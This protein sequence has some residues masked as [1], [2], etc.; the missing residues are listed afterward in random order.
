MN[1]SPKRKTAILLTTA[2]LGA[3]YAGSAIAQADTSNTEPEKIIEEVLVTGTLIRGLDAPTG[4]NLVTID[5]GQIR[6]SGAPSATELVSEKVTQLPTFNTVPVGAAG[7]ANTVPRLG[8]RGFGN[9]AGNASGGTATLVMFNG[10]RVVFTGYGSSDVDPSSIP[11]DILQTVQ[12]MPDG[13]SAAYGSDAVGGVIN[14]VTLKK[15]DGVQLH[16]QHGTVDDYNENTTSLTAGTSWD[17]GNVLFNTSF[18]NNSALLK[19]DRSYTSADFRSFGGGDY[20]LTTCPDG[21]FVVD[22]TAYAAPDFTPL[23]E[24][25]KCEPKAY[26]SMVPEQDRVSAFTYFEQ[27]I[28]DDLTF[29]VDAFYSKRR[30]RHYKD[31]NA[32]GSSVTIDSSNPYFTPVAGETEQRVNFSYANGIGVNR[33]SPQELTSWQISPSL[34]WRVGDNWVIDSDFIVGESEAEIHDRTGLNTNFVDSTN[35]N[36]YDTSQMP[37][38]LLGTVTNFEQ[39]FIGVN[40]LESARITADGSIFSIEGGDV[41]LAIGAEST[42]QTLEAR[43]RFGAIGL[44][45]FRS[46]DNDR[47]VNAVYGELYVPLV[48]AANGRPG[49]RELNFALAVRYDDYSDFGSTTNPR[50]G[51]NYRPFEDLGI[52]ANYQ[53]TFTAASLADSG[54]NDNQLQVIAN[55]QPDSYRIY[56]AGT[57]ANIDPTEGE[58]Y[59]IG[60]DWTPSFAPGLNV[61]AT[62]WNTKLEN[63]ISQALAAFGGSVPTS[64]TSYALCGDGD[65][66]YS[67]SVNGSCTEAQINDILN[68]LAA[69]VLNP[70]GAPGISTISDLFQPGITVATLIDARRGNFGLENISG[71][72]FSAG[73]DFDTP[74]GN[75]F[76]GVNG[77]VML[78]KEIAANATAPFVN[79]LDGGEVNPQASEWGMTVT[80]SLAFGP[81]TVRVDV[82][83]SGGYDI[84]PGTLGQTSIGS[85]TLTNLSATHEIGRFLGMQETLLEF[86]IKNLFDEEPPWNSAQGI[87]DSY[88]TAGTLGRL[89]RVGVRTKF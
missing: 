75:A 18:A 59:S 48:S 62:Y 40:K 55:P 70:G 33:E 80:G 25:P 42:K 60:A 37:A 53:T 28:R 26:D 64:A 39:L 11:A 29:S 14:F 81:T 17:T 61:S 85:F 50:I 1:P 23:S 82:T 57:G 54:L 78:E 79:Y 3:V 4:S 73:Y 69:G 83:H 5:S 67:P 24:Q 36:P 6:A 89:F 51:I 86:G 32:L 63:L 13:G 43:N 38:S 16:V 44:G 19:G 84:P 41:K 66:R 88:P 49:L 46:L 2:T 74:V 30:A 71:I 47:K 52:R 10:H 8:L 21:S 56:V 27:D 68:T 20:R 7:V 76:L 22:G 31:V 35:I 9:S 72:D 12:V 65:S 15:F 87:S 45:D 34:T 58:T 77:T